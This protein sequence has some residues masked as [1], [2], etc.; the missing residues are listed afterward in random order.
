M[1]NPTVWAMV[2]M[3]LISN[4][5]D[6]LVNTEVECGCQLDYLMVCGLAE[7]DKCRAGYLQ[8]DGNM[9]LEKEKDK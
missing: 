7:L 6:G 2:K 5:F 3:H 4:G 1:T 8:K 9:G